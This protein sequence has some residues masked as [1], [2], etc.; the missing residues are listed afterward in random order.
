MSAVKMKFIRNN[1][2]NR[3]TLVVAAQR[4]E[5]LSAKQAER[6]AESASSLLLDFSYE[7]QRASGLALLNYDVEG[8]WSLRTYLAKR[9]LNLEELM[10]LLEAT[11]G[12][13][14]Y[15]AAEHLPQEGLLFDPEYVFVDAQCCPHFALLPLEGVP[16][17]TRNSPLALLGAIADTDKLQFASP[18]AEG[19]SRRL[20]DLLVDLEGVFSANK[21]RRFIE[22]EQSLADDD[23]PE[24]RQ[25]VVE[26][27][28]SSVWASAGGGSANTAPDSGAFFWNPLVGLAEEETSAPVEEKPTVVTPEP[29]AATPEP[30]VKEPEPVAQVPVVRQQPEP[31]AVSVQP[32]PVTVPVQ[33][34]AAPTA[35]TGN[36]WLVRLA[37]GERFLLPLGQQVK[38]GRGSACEIRLLS[39]RKFSRTH[40]AFTSTGQM[41]MVTDMG[42]ANGVFVNGQRL[43]GMQSV[44]VTPGQRLRLADEDFSVM[45]G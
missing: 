8:L 22:Q 38:A 34:A 17:Q 18:D 14:D 30:V 2:T 21:F 41:V 19:L 29:V 36:L 35:T 37:T 44:L 5:T 24:A 39:N 40:A 13:L 1:K 9:S 16:F 26:P 23:V 10:G 20:G 43:T 6:L 33:A 32:A 4:G 3:R 15:C 12:V 28:T 7:K 42:A 31:V 25:S 11:Q 45:I 27:G